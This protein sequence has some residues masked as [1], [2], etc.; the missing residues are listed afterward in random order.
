MGGNG[1]YIP[2]A[3]GFCRGWEWLIFFCTF[4]SFHV[5]MMEMSVEAVCSTKFPGVAF[6]NGTCQGSPLQPFSEMDQIFRVLRL[7]TELDDDTTGIT[8]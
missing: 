7:D 5:K 6:Q 4:P 3:V 1:V 2:A 8:M